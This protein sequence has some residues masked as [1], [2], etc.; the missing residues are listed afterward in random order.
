MSNEADQKKRTPTEVLVQAMELAEEMAE[1]VVIFRLMKDGQGHSGMG[2]VTE[3][4]ELAQKF[5][6]L[7]EAKLAMFHKSYGERDMR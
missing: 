3:L 6:F 1:C 4:P 7:E 2:W 5:A